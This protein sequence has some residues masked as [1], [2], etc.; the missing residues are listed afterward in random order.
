MYAEKARF[1]EYEGEQQ[2]LYYMLWAM[3][4]VELNVLALDYTFRIHLNNPQDP[5]VMPLCRSLINDLVFYHF[6][7]EED[8]LMGKTIARDSLYKLA[9]IANPKIKVAAPSSKS[10]K[11][12]RK[13]TV[14]AKRSTTAKIQADKNKNIY[15]TPTTII[16]K[17]K[18]S[19]A[20][21]MKPLLKEMNAKQKQKEYKKAGIKY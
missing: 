10:K 2:Q 17:T 16:G 5:E 11:V 21:G 14:K 9:D 13:T 19:A 18:N 4:D 20:C 3:S 15:Y 8:F 12:T 1:E 6:N 7:D